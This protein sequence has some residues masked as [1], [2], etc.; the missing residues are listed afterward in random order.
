MTFKENDKAWDLLTRGLIHLNQR[1]FETNSSESGF[2]K[3]IMWF[4]RKEGVYNFQP[5]LNPQPKSLKNLSFVFEFLYLWEGKNPFFTSERREKRQQQL[6]VL[7]DPELN[8]STMQILK[9][10]LA[11]DKQKAV[12]HLF[13][14]ETINK[15]QVYPFITD[16][17]DNNN[18]GGLLSFLE[19]LESKTTNLKMIRFY[20]LSD[21]ARI[22]FSAGF[23]DNLVTSSTENDWA[24]KKEHLKT[25]LVYLYSQ[26]SFNTSVWRNGI[27]HLLMEQLDL[28]LGEIKLDQLR[29]DKVEV[30][31]SIKALGLF[32]Q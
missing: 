6:A 22:F 31:K 2:L 14:L 27:T 9:K 18:L 11:E 16:Y 21:Y 30:A 26:T 7:F 25:V 15:W 8:S 12:K 20:A 3:K 4:L 13:S 10:L 24:I 19:N 32:G 28:N 23:Y 5:F 1:K 29:I 17:V